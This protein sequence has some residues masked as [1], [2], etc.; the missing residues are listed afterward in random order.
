MK[1]EKI[2]KWVDQSVMDKIDNEESQNNQTFGQQSDS[3]STQF[4]AGRGGSAMHNT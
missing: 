2:R 3:E 4:E 1:Q